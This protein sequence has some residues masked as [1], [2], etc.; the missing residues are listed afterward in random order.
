MIEMC[1]ILQ[2]LTNIMIPDRQN[3]LAWANDF[4]ATTIIFDLRHSVYATKKES[5]KNESVVHELGHLFGIRSD[6][7]DSDI[8]C[9]ANSGCSGVNDKCIM[10]YCRD[11]TDEKVD[12]DKETD[13]NQNC[14]FLIRMANDPR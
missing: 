10:T 6:H 2:L 11:L 14:Y 1:F 3:A 8:N 7:V 4:R 12:F 5:A 9:V 13:I